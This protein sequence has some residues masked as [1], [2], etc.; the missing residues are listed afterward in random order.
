MRSSSR[1]PAA[2][3]LTFLLLLSGCVQPGADGV[4]GA[5][6]TQGPPGADG[7]DGVNGTDGADGSDGQDGEDGLPGPPGADGQDGA[8]GAPGLPG[9]DGQDGVNGTDGAD[10]KDGV[11]GTNGTDGAPGPPGADGQDGVNGTDAPL[12]LVD[13]TIIPA[14]DPRCPGGGVELHV[15][16]DTNGSGTLEVEEREETVV[17]CHGEDGEDFVPPVSPPAPPAPLLAPFA[18]DAVF[19]SWR[20]SMT[21]T[22]SSIIGP[23]DCTSNASWLREDG[24]AMMAMM[25]DTGQN[26]YIA[27]VG[28]ASTAGCDWLKMEDLLSAAGNETGRSI[29]MGL[30]DHLSYTEYRSMMLSYA[31]LEVEDHVGMRVMAD[32]FHQAIQAPWY[33]GTGMT[34]EE[35]TNLSELL[36]DVGGRH[37][38]FM[39]YVP[40]EM[41]MAYAAPTAVLGV[42]SCQSSLVGCTN[43][44]YS[45]HPD[46]LLSV[47]WNITL[48]EHEA[49]HGA[50]LTGFMHETFHNATVPLDRD[51]RLIVTF[52]G[53]EVDNRSLYSAT[54]PTQRVERLNI[55]L[56]PT[57]AGQH[58]I[59]LQIKAVDNIITRTWT[60]MAFFGDLNVEAGSS[61]LPLD[62]ESAWYRN[63][64]PTNSSKT[65]YFASSNAD[66]RLDEVFDG[67]LFRWGAPS[68]ASAADHEAFVSWL[69]G[70]MERPC[71][72]VYW[73]NLQWNAPSGTMA[74]HVAFI[75]ATAAHT[76]GLI[77][78]RL[79][80]QQHNTSAGYYAENRLASSTAPILAMYPA[81]VPAT[82]GWYQSWTFTAN[83]T[84]PLNLTFDDSIKTS[85]VLDRMVVR[86][87]VNGT[88]VHEHD[89]GEAGVEAP[90]SLSVTTGEV[91]EVR[92]ETVDSF[93][94]L[95]WWVEVNGTLAGHDLSRSSMTY[96]AGGSAYSTAVY[97]H[98]RS[99]FLG[100]DLR[101]HI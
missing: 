92:M 59:T 23:G 31:A 17:L 40:A 84:G 3:L 79:D 81:F 12:L 42:A 46:H 52:D 94:S 63:E 26:T 69:C 54:L 47:T 19:G 6:G 48:S 62:V 11:N 1:V 8:D 4:N 30:P 87:F 41:A 98:M 65:S 76:D 29:W 57:Y 88:Q 77:V 15:G 86:V 100:L 67:L 71:I 25:N 5:D 39:P 7:M 34:G 82:E 9:A 72:E 73:G 44:N 45:L 27:H 18:E 10:G 2:L 58:Q 14:N 74:D 75:Q 89:P 13:S 35:L 96:E 33:P 16:S 99:A 32:D 24:T 38:P 36:D 37:I 51:A 80:N 93:G 97:A 53:Q 22:N 28:T 49:Q 91:V 60:K 21:N 56:P 20:S 95:V 83:A 68:N 50:L 90:V 43:A 64:H 85:A 78:W 55:N 61:T 101:P 70:S 66:W